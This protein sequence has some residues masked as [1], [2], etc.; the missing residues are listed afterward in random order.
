MLDYLINKGMKMK[1]DANE[2]RVPVGKKVNLAKWSTHVEPAYKS[3][4]KY[5]KLL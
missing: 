3:K 5:S 2:F 4:K 1:I